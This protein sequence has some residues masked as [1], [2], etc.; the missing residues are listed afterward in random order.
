[1]AIRR[2][3]TRERHSRLMCS[4]SRLPAGLIGIALMVLALLALTWL[5]TVV[6]HD[7]TNRPRAEITR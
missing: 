1:M 3:E 6:V 2:E 4:K 7:W 5:F